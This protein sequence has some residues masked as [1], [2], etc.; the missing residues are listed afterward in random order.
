MELYKYA[1]RREDR[2]VRIRIISILKNEEPV[3]PEGPTEN[4]GGFYYKPGKY[5]LS[6]EEC[7]MM[8]CFEAFFKYREDF[9]KRPEPL[10]LNSLCSDFLNHVLYAERYEVYAAMNEI[11][12]QLC[13]RRLF[14]DPGNIRQCA[15]EHY[16]LLQHIPREEA[17]EMFGP[18]EDFDPNEA[19]KCGDVIDW[20]RYSRRYE[21]KLLKRTVSG[22]YGTGD[23]IS[24]GIYPYDYDA[25]P[26]PVKWIVLEREGNTALLL[27]LYAF[28]TVHFS[29][30]EITSAETVDIL[31]DKLHDVCFKSL[32]KV[33]PLDS[34]LIPFYDGRMVSLMTSEHLQRLNWGKAQ[35]GEVVLSPYL[36][37]R[38]HTRDA[39]LPWI[40]LNSGLSAK[41]PFLSMSRLGTSELS[42]IDSGY[43]YALRPLIRI[44]C[45]KVSEELRPFI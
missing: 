25:T 11:S 22:E 23:L 38:N 42:P 2:R 8:I 28:D 3:V 32:F 34:K 45:D 10:V 14:T 16:R 20:D 12:E 19:E 21:K 4:Y 1:L 43:T 17:D 39:K 36:I 30:E 35:F 29:K 26:A 6:R 37:R 33:Y 18:F 9:E 5:L 13:G 31:L 27:S 40:L 15:K 41:K 7:E 24:L 44:D